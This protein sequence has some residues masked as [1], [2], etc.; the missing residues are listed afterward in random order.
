MY[1]SCLMGGMPECFVYAIGARIGSDLVFVRV[2]ISERPKQ[3]LARLQAENPLA[4][5]LLA[6][7]VTRSKIRARQIEVEAHLA[8]QPWRKTGGWFS[9]S[10]RV[11]KA[12]ELMHE[13]RNAPKLFSA[14]MSAW[15]GMRGE[16]VDA[17]TIAAALGTA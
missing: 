2:G 13:H 15:A 8:L 16:I 12:V 6:T 17:A 5:S 10:P 4:L 9:V 7:M 1:S 3:R 14:H 11:M